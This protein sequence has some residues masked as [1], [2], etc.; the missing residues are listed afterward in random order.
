M[1]NKKYSIE[2]RAT[3]AIFQRAGRSAMHP[4]RLAGLGKHNWGIRAYAS[5]L[6]FVATVIALPAQTFTNLHSFD[7]ADGD[8]P[9]Y[10]PLVQGTD[11]NFYG[12]TYNLGANGI[13]PYG[14]VFRIT[15]G[16]T[17]TTLYSF[18]S[19]SGCSDGESPTGAFLQAINGKFY[20]T[21][22]AGGANGD[23]T[24][25]EITTGG[26]LTTLYSFCSQSGCADGATPF[27]GLVQ[28]SNGDLYGTTAYG[29]ANGLGTVFKVTPVGTLT[30]LHSFAGPD[31]ANPIAGLVQ[32][33]YRD[34]YGTTGYGGSSSNCEEG[35]GTIFKITPGGTLTTLHSFDGSDGSGP[36]VSELVQAPDGNFYGTTQYGG[37]TSDANCEEG[38]GTVFRFTYGGTLTT[39]D[40]K[41]VV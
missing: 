16:G 36:I 9:E 5:L 2:W 1:R 8:G 10:A 24:V 11:G 41:S 3:L 30:V 20:G 4:L 7:G 21:T 27:A 28:G 22:S 26:M 39:L 18:C 32:T 40:R 23:G 6:L 34:L 37:S 29:G 15:P 13:G 35:C 17:L 14:T 12:T 33:P 19:Q 31:G 25:F 38:C